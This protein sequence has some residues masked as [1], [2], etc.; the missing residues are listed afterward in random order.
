MK[1][2]QRKSGWDRI[3][4]PLAGRQSR[5][6]AAVRSGLVGAGALAG[7]TAVSSAVSSVRGKRD[8]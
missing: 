3:K 4:E 5:V 8:K 6:R 7:L 1:V 2:L